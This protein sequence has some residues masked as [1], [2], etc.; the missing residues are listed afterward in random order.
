MTDLSSVELRLVETAEEAA[1][2]M[3]WLGERR[4]ILGFD[5]ETTGLDWWT[6]NF[7]RMAQ[8]GDGRTGWAMD[9]RNWRGIISEAL[10]KYEGQIVAHNATFDMHAIDNDGLPMPAAHRWE[11]TKIMDYIVAPNRSHALKRV[12]QRYWPDA[13]IGQD[14]LKKEFA[15]TK[16]DWANIPTDNQIYWTYAA[17]DP[18]L[19]ALL[20]EKLEPEV[21]PFQDAYDREMAALMVL[22]RAE[23]KGLRID[24][25]YTANLMLEWNQEMEALQEDLASVG[26]D[27][28]NA[29]RQVAQAMQLTEK[30]EPDALT[31]TGLPMLNDKVLRGIDSYIS[32]RVLRYRRL[33]K[34]T[35]TYLERFYNQRDAGDRLH[36]S[37]NTV[38]ARTGR[39]S[40]TRP[41]LQTL[42]RGPIIRNCVIPS[43]GQALWACDYD[44]MEMRVFAHYANETGLIEAVHAGLDLHT[45]AA[46]EVYG[47]PSITKDDPRRQLAKNTQFGLIYGAGPA[48]IAETAGVTE[49]E[50]K[51]FLAM[52]EGRFSQ[53]RPF[54]REVDAIARTRRVQEN[55]AYVRSWGGRKLPAD[56]DK[57]YALVNYLI[58]GSCADVLKQKIIEVDAAG[59]GDNI[60]IPV[61][62]ELL[63]EFPIG[64]EDGPREVKALMEDHTSFVVPLSAELSGPYDRWGAKYEKKEEKPSE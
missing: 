2:F 31:P 41:A 14:L 61:H 22:Y 40:I 52:Y 48:K 33:R 19:A 60:I 13:A 30:W 4:P 8:F 51:S 18:V 36:A 49:A 47:D 32:T 20:W 34:W 39:M 27:N 58:Q 44:T 1:E 57:L 7:L 53:V 28:P 54:M 62:D 63:M 45:Y 23:A 43:E 24:P 64:E 29:A 15:R 35:S 42:P 21:R 11:D 16:T 38:G 37:I 50:A 55:V 59:F 26:L 5:T 12:T 9:A 10:T 3:R 17:L 56:D 25:A 6:P 46:Q